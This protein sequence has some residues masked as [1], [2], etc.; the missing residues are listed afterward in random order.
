ML[1]TDSGIREAFAADHDRLDSLF[2]SY[3]RIKRKDSDRAKEFFKEFKFALQRHIVWEE[4]ILFPLFEEKTGIFH[5]GPTEV[6]RQ[7]HRLIGMYLEAVH[8]K[9]R[10][11]DP[12]SD[13]EVYALQSA[14]ALHNQ[15]EENI[16]YPTLDRLLSDEEKANAF[17]AMECVPE[18]TILM[19]RRHLP[20]SGED[21]EE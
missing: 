2:E 9:V 4:Q 6:M 3:R 12:N 11:R 21:S 10:K 19:T 7:E 17:T 16:L 15:K 20:Q 1:E 13:N 8:D 14:L 18:E 5:A